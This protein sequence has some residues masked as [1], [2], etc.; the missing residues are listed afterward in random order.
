MV[1][2]ANRRPARLPHTWKGL[3]MAHV[4]SIGLDVH[5]RSIKA[6]AFNP[7]TGEIARRSFGY[8]P[9][10]VASWI[11]GFEDPKAVYES[12]V[13]GFHLQR[14]LESLGVDCVIGAVSKMDK[15]AADKRRKTDKR[16]AAF[17]ARQLAL[18]TVPEVHVPDEECE[19]GHDLSRALADARD[20]VTACKQ[21]LSK[22]LLRYGYVYDEADERGRRKTTWTKAHW[23]WIEAV[24][25]PQPAAREALDYYIDR[26]RRAIRDKKDL[27]AK[28]RAR[29]EEARWKPTVDALRSLK[30]IDVVTAYALAVEVDGFSRFRNASAF[31]SWLGLVPSE[32]SSGEGRR[33]GGITKSGNK[34]LRKLLVEAAWHYASAT[35]REKAPS[36]GQVVP[37][38]VRRHAAKGVRRLVDR[39]AAMAEAG[40]RSVVANCATA[41][42]LACWCWAIGCM[43]EAA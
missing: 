33:R 32:H 18:G 22:F 25:M 38:E 43:V 13:T 27:E 7:L 40:K 4:T 2:S 21:R 14:E 12:G 16:D 36:R 17:L 35:R 41:R 23:D 39:R 26:C 24:D 11:L 9:A 3:T 31:A 29:A 6:C 30:G 8:E 15:P 28:V 5:A 19:A 1:L 37:S 20:E 42:E 10:E 34:H